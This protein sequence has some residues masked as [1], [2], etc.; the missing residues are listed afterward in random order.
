M[1]CNQDMRDIDDIRR[2]GLKLI[3]AEAGGPTGA[4]K[5]LGMSVA[6]FSNLRD[7]AKDS[8]TKKPRGMRK[9]TARKIEKEA[10]KPCGWL[11]VDHSIRTINFDDCTA[12]QTV[13]I[14]KAISTL[15]EALNSLPHDQAAEKAAD[16][17]A[18]LARAPDSAKARRAVAAALN[19]SVGPLTPD[20]LAQPRPKRGI[21]AQDHQHHQD[22]E[23]KVA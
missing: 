13:S 18:T 5:L 14:E 17:L 10:G 7:G 21:Q 9:E 3:E 6:Q 1:R 20:P 12:S 23:R 15:A 22:Q 2:A 8:K 4:A 19:V 11:D 16:T